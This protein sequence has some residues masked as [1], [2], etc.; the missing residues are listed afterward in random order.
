MSSDG[1]AAN[2]RGLTPR[3]LQS[4]SR[5]RAVRWS[6]VSV[7]NLTAGEVLQHDVTTFQKP[8]NFS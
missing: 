6:L 2:V 7:T 5:A 1:E 3:S 8:S 4:G